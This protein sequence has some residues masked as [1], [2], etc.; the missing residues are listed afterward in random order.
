MFRTW[1]TAKLV[2]LT[3]GYFQPVSFQHTINKTRK[4]DVFARKGKTGWS[5]KCTIE[6]KTEAHAKELVLEEHV[7]LQ[8]HQLAVYPKR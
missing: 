5:Y 4:F 1:K 7:D 3:S 6:A 2:K 8:K